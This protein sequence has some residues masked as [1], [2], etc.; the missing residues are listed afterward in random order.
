MAIDDPEYLFVYELSGMHNAERQSAVW[1]SEMVDQIRDANL[2]QVMR[3]EKQ[4]CQ[5]R[6]KNLETCFHAMGTPARGDVPSLAVDGMRAEYQR[7]LSQEPSPEAV[8][9]CTFG[10]AMKLSYFGIGSYRGLVDKS[11]MLGKIQ[12]AQILQSNLVMNA[13]SAGRLEF[14][15]HE[16][17]QRVMATVAG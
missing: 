7:F 10:Y 16:V 5:Q 3:V 11:T 6:I 15:S 12:C 9:M 1:R 14:I 17:S 8:D 4:E 2:Q 13:E